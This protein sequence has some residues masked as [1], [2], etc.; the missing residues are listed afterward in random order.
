MPSPLLY[1]FWE[2]MFKNVFFTQEW[3]NIRRAM[4]GDPAVVHKKMD[5]NWFIAIA[6]IQTKSNTPATDK[7]FVY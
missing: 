3:R 7:V 1:V 5:G 6:H 2:F 4:L